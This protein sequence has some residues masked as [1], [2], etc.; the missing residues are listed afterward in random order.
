[1]CIRDRDNILEDF[2]AQSFSISNGTV[3]T[4]PVL[5]V[6]ATIDELT[7]AKKVYV[8]LRSYSNEGITQPETG[9]TVYPRCNGTIGIY[10][11]TKNDSTSWSLTQT[12]SD[13]LSDLCQYSVNYYVNIF[14]E[15]EETAPPTAGVH[16]SSGNKRM[17]DNNLQYSMFYEPDPT[18]LLYPVQI[19]N[20]RADSTIDTINDQVSIFTAPTEQTLFFMQSASWTDPWPEEACPQTAYTLNVTNDLGFG[21]TITTPSLSEITESCTNALLKDLSND[22]TKVSY[23]ISLYSIEPLSNI[24]SYIFSPYKDQRFPN[25]S[26]DGGI[27]SR[28]L[29]V[30]MA[31]ADNTSYSGITN[32]G[33]IFNISWEFDKAFLPDALSGYEDKPIL[34]LRPTDENG[35]N[36]GEISYRFDVDAAGSEADINAPKIDQVTVSDFS[37]SD[38]PQR[39]YAKF[40]VDFTNDAESGAL[41]SVRDIWIDYYGGNLCQRH[42]VYVRDDLDGKIDTSISK[43]TATVPWLKQNEGTFVIL[44]MNIN[45]HGYGES[46]YGYDAG[47]TSIHPSVGSTFSVGDTSNS[48]PIYSGDYVAGEVTV[49]VDENTQTIGT[50]AASGPTDL[51]IVYTTSSWFSSSKSD[52]TIFDKV[53]I[54]SSTGELSYIENP[55]YESDTNYSG[56]VLV[57]ATSANG[58]TSNLYVTVN[59]QNVN[60]NAPVITSSASFSANEGQTEVDCISFTDADGVTIPAP[61]GTQSCS[62]PV[63]F[64]YSLT[65]DSL[66]I[67]TDGKISFKTAPDYET[68]NSYSSTL[69]VSDGVNTTDQA[70]T[71]SVIDVNDNDPI[72][73]ESSTT[74]T[75]NENQTGVGQIIVSDA[76]TNSSFTFAIVSDYEDGA[77]FSIDADGVITFKANA[78]HET[79]GQ[80]TIKVNISD[81]TNTVT[82]IFTI[83]LNDICELDFS[84]VIYSGQTTENYFASTRPLDN[85]TIN[86]KFFYEFNVD[87]TDDACTVPSDETYNFSLTGDDASAFV[88]ES[89]TGNDSDKHFIHLNKIFDHESPTDLNSDNV[90]NVTLNV[91]LGDFT[92][93]KNLSLTVYDMHEFGEIQTFTFDESSSIFTISYLTNDI[94]PNTSKLKFTIRGPSFPSTNTYLTKTVD[95]D[96]SNTSYSMELDAAAYSQEISEDDTTIYGGYYL[97]LIHI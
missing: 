5:T 84:N 73:D 25:P 15:T 12:L 13:E 22:P 79:A 10:E 30:Q 16:L 96:S 69:T 49:S 90:Y 61:D 42:V 47:G 35:I 71:V 52:Q 86:S 40:E 88:L 8:D 82:Q 39:N 46:Y 19:S 27:F 57:T 36:L 60:D 32:N 20:P 83:N 44:G 91:T 38:F 23:N 7:K 33:R 76:D 17:L 53:Q 3:S 62:N 97:S 72:I 6:N 55:D 43:A 81:G 89:S 2:I 21:E 56:G 50:F 95:Y 29:S 59:L 4:A 75:V 85:D 9:T 11:M 58:Q 94:P 31:Q 63:G 64:T 77:L 51:S 92:E 78:N 18:Y 54:N 65:G 74:F 66:E 41:T 67:D 1:M 37:D 87:T 48:C 45:D 34:F 14:D 70:I 80:Y 93:S 24:Y 26:D 68:Q 28:E